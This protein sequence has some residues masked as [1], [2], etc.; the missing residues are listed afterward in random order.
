MAQGRH[1]FVRA[2]ALVQHDLREQVSEGLFINQ[3]L[4]RPWAD[5]NYLTKG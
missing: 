2:I 3:D 1:L 5:K 4:N